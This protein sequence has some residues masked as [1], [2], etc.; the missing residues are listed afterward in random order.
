MCESVEV[1]CC[2]CADSLTVFTGSSTGKICVWD[3][4]ER[5]PRFRFRRTLTAH[6]EAITTLVACSSQTLLVSG[7]R[8]GTAVLWH[9]SACTFIRQLRP[10]PCSVTTV[11]V[12]DITVNFCHILISLIINS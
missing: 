2:A 10:H 11:A 7:S 1:T 12:N 8:D 5:H 3:L 9:L 4:S 6:V